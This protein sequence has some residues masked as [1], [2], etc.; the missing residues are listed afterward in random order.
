MNN[1]LVVKNLTKTFKA[2]WQLFGPRDKDFTAVDNISFTLKKGEILGLLGPNGAGK[3]TMMQML[4]GVLTPTHGKIEYFG[5]NYE[6]DRTHIMQSIGYANAYAKMP[7]KLTVRENL[8]FFGRLYSMSDAQICTRMEALLASFDALPLLDKQTGGLSAGQA[9]RVTLVKAFL[10]NPRIVLLDEPT[11][12]LDPDI[13]HSVRHFLLEQKKN[14]NV[15]IILA[16]H[17][18]DEVS[19]MC[20]R[21][22]VL[23]KGV[24]IATDTPAHLAATVSKSR[25]IL[26]ISQGLEKA[27][28][29][30]TQK[31]YT[32]SVSDWVIEIHIDEHLISQLLTDLGQLSVSYTHI[33]LQKP[34][35]EDYF[36]STARSGK[37]N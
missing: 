14:N 15:S 32:H 18:M 36:L 6:R 25:L 28:D 23:Q 7:A 2:S 5:K 3:S 29:F 31:D 21:V 19:Q 12:P 4:L 34:T 22:L 16:S 27:I 11:G 9:T 17:D 1:E 10:P 37:G 24:I 13:T 33:A 26:T 35:L 20:D 8:L 30:V